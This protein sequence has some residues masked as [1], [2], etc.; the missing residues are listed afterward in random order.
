MLQKY[1]H[2]KHQPES[3]ATIQNG[4]NPVSAGRK[5]WSQAAEFAIFCTILIFPQNFAEVEK[6]LTMNT[7]IGLM[8]NFIVK[9]IELNCLKQWAL[10]LRSTGIMG[11]N[12]R[13]FLGRSLEDFFSKESMRIFETSLENVFGRIWEDLPKKILRNG[14]QFL[15]LLW[16]LLRKNLGKYIGTPI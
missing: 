8:R 1:E 2:N 6:W 16:K 5:I 3:S 10:L 7:I 13:N 12:F 15:K 11:P 9:K 14:A 4:Y